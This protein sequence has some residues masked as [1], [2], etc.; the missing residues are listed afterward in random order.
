[1]FYIS[2]SGAEDCAFTCLSM[3]LANCHKDKNYLYLKHDDRKYNFRELIE[4]AKRYNTT[5]LGVKVTDPNELL[6]CDK[7][8]FVAVLRNKNNTQHSVLVYKVT[9][10]KIYL[11]DPCLG[12]RI[13][14]FNEFVYRWTK[15]ALII[16][17]YTK[18]KCNVLY[19]SF[20]RRKDKVLLLIYQII[21]S[22]SIL[23]GT[24]F[25]DKESYFFIPIIF[26]SVFVIFEILFRY[27]LLKSMEHLDESIFK[28]EIVRPASGYKEVYT[29]I[30]E[31]KASSLTLIPNIIYSLL[32]SV[33]IAIILVLNNYLNFV[34]IVLSF[35]FALIENFAVI[36]KFKS[37]EAALIE[38]ENEVFESPTDY[39]FKFFSDRATKFANKIGYSKQMFRYAEIG[40][41]VIT[42]ILI[43]YLTNV[44]NVAYVI[45]YLCINLFLI[46][47]FG[48]LFIF[49]TK[50][51]NFDSIRAKLI[52]YLK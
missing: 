28:E 11:L 46:D 29:T 35:A 37:D 22:L 3:L 24:Y 33:F 12:K 16:K 23:T 36:P 38:I 25:I 6:K 21:A 30:Q 32:I 27:R 26:F 15:Y 10:T 13:I 8:P 51:D 2:Q 34:Y 20:L 41:L 44:A 40:I 42:S 50:K 7:F 45:F 19:P 52:N 1:M 18:T 4:I 48:K 14:S 17:E 5:L 43:M 49:S 9:R 39:Q 47:T 31:Y